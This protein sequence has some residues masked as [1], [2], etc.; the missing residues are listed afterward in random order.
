MYEHM[1]VIHKGWIPER[2][3]DVEDM[4]FSF[5]HVDVDLYDPTIDSLKFF[6]DRMTTGGIIMCDD[7]GSVSCPGAKKAFDEFF[8]DK[9]ENILELPSA[10]A[11]VVKA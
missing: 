2:F 3:K 5:L 11:I 6:Y 1:L 8:A 9:Q 7:Y 10:Q 4:K